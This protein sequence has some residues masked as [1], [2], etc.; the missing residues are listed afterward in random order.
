MDY[1][2]DAEQSMIES[3]TRKYLLNVLGLKPYDTLCDKLKLDESNWMQFHGILFTAIFNVLYAD[4]IGRMEDVAKKAFIET[5]HA[6][7]TA[8]LTD[9]NTSPD[10]LPILENIIESLKTSLSMYAR[11][12]AERTARV[13]AE[14]AELKQCQADPRGTIARTARYPMTAAI[15]AIMAVSEPS[16]RSVPAED[17]NKRLKNVPNGRFALTIKN[18]SFVLS[19]SNNDNTPFSI[20]L[21]TV[22]KVA[23]KYDDL[24]RRID[25]LAAEKQHIVVYYIPRRSIE[26]GI[27]PKKF[28]PL[29]WFAP[30]FVA[31]TDLEV[32][33]TVTLN[34]Q[35]LWTGPSDT[36]MA[37]GDLGYDWQKSIRHELPLTKMVFDLK[38]IE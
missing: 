19:V 23:G 36:S 18:G 7:A 33:D 14:L 37:K 24:H 10:V 4:Y 27:W 17:V 3:W 2:D 32:R 20:E 11:L 30:T 5:M 1:D 35:N 16:E 26:I 21:D 28:R 15:I 9:E 13:A 25:T 38:F 6:W 22:F 12:D 8:T 31:P 29:A 34:I